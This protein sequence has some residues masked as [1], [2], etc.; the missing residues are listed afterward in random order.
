MQNKASKFIISHKLLLIGL[1]LYLCM[2]AV[3]QYFDQWISGESFSGVAYNGL[4]FYLPTLKVENRILDIIPLS[5]LY[6]GIADITDVIHQ[7]ISLM[8][9][10]LVTFSCVAMNF[11]M[12]KYYETNNSISNYERWI[13]AHLYDNVLFYVISVVMKFISKYIDTISILDNFFPSIGKIFGT[14]IGTKLFGTFVLLIIFFLTVIL[15]LIPLMPTFIYYVIYLI[16]LTVNLLV[17][18]ILDNVCFDKIFGDTFF[19]REVLTAVLALTLVMVMNILV[20]RLYEKIQGLSMK[21]A[22]WTVN[23]IKKGVLAVRD[24]FKRD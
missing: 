15:I 23:G 22:Y 24:K 3:S 21:P 13:T 8:F 17:V 1:V 2:Y 19:P 20:E 14:S 6:F 9:F 5:I 7:D 11:F 4:D 18:Q 12:K 10:V 16:V